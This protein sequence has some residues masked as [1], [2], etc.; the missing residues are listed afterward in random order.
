MCIV[1]A[2]LSLSLKYAFLPST[3]KFIVFFPCFG[4]LLQVRQIV[5]FYEWRFEDMNIVNRLT[6]A[7]RWLVVAIMVHAKQASHA[8]HN[9]HIAFLFE[10]DDLKAKL[11]RMLVLE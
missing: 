8:R 7:T 4:I 3:K 1:F 6:L 10:L 5:L 2:C 11:Q 9:R